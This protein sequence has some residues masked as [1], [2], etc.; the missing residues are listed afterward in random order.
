MADTYLELRK[1]NAILK[2]ALMELEQDFRSSQQ[3][4]DH[5]RQQ[6]NELKA[7][8]LAL[9]RS[10]KQ[11]AVRT[12]FHTST[13]T[14]P[15]TSDQAAAIFAGPITIT[16]AEWEKATASDEVKAGKGVALLVQQQEN[17]D[18]LI[19]L[20]DVEQEQPEPAPE[21]P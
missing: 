7:V 10:A 5:L 16:K 17:G 21:T 9:V 1:Q 6:A 8:C 15:L 3:A 18:Y 2:A 13:L 12:A 19:D 14:H 11:A 4:R 20:G